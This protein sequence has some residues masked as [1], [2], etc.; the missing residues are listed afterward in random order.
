MNS[1][2]SATA[3]AEYFRI[4]AVPVA[5]QMLRRG[6]SGPAAYRRHDG[7]WR[8]ASESFTR[9]TAIAS[10]ARAAAALTDRAA[11]PET[12]TTPA[13]AAA[14]ASGG[15]GLDEILR[16]LAAAVDGD[17]Q[18]GRRHPGRDD[19]PLA[20]ARP[21]EQQHRAAAA[22]EEPERVDPGVPDRERQQVAYA[23]CSGPA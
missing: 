1:P 23:M 5:R 9:H 2:S 21:G 22:A 13:H 6:R 17:R 12:V 14:S 4:V 15:H 16:Q 3:S 19:Q 18:A 10:N 8:R 7:C 20:G 11:V